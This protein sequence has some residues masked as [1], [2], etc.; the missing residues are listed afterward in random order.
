MVLRRLR[1]PKLRQ[2]WR[3][4]EFANSFLKDP[5]EDKAVIFEPKQ[6]KV[7]HIRGGTITLKV[8]NSISNDQLGV[9]E[10]SLEPGI[11]GA[12]L[13]FHRFMDETFIVNEGSLTESHGES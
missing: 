4:T 6:G 3:M 10:I 2:L 13:H 12:Q 1:L 11:V 8:T 9:Y 5:L 7:I